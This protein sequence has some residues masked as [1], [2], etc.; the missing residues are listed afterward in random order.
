[1]NNKMVLIDSSVLAN[2]IS[3]IT[4]SKDTIYKLYYSVK[5]D[6]INNTA[7]SMGTDFKFNF[8]D[9]FNWLTNLA[10]LSG[11]GKFE[12][13]LLDKDKKEGVIFIENS[14]IAQALKNKTTIPTDHIIR[15][16]IAGGASVSLNENIDAIEE[17]C[18]ALG[19]ERCK[20]IFKPFKNIQKTEKYEEQINF[21]I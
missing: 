11:W 12:W 19:A 3:S 15:G 20:I 5:K 7:K 9:Y 8:N 14:V 21:N 1:M 16:F 17:E 2:F 13:H 10:M 18:I 4:D 6:F